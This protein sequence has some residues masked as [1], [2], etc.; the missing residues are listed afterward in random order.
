MLTRDPQ[1]WKSKRIR[2]SE[3]KG[4][5]TKSLVSTSTA[6]KYVLLFSLTLNNTA[7]NTVRKREFQLPT[8]TTALYSRQRFFRMQLLLVFFLIYYANRLRVHQ[9]YE[10]ASAKIS[11]TLPAET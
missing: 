9:Q 2:S 6:Y 3:K 10:F 1:S 4:S 11:T 5:E 8:S 7:K